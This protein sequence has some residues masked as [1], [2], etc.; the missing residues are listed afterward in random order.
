MRLCHGVRLGM[1]L[2]DIEYGLRVFHHVAEWEWA[3]HWRRQPLERPFPVNNDW[4][5]GGR[6]LHYLAL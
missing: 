4:H 5:K 3:F 1:V 2:E 6:G